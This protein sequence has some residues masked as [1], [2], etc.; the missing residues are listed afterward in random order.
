MAVY[1]Y[2]KLL[3]E[4]EKN[5]KS[6]LSKKNIFQNIFENLNFFKKKKKTK[7]SKSDKTVSAKKTTKNNISQEP[8]QKVFSQEQNMT[9]VKKKSKK[10]L[11]IILIIG[12]LLGIREYNLHYRHKNT[13]QNKV[14]HAQQV[15]VKVK[16]D[17]KKNKKPSNSIVINSTNS[18]V[19]KN[20]SLQKQ[21]LEL[22]ATADK[23][24]SNQANHFTKIEMGKECAK[25]NNTISF[26]IGLNNIFYAGENIFKLKESIPYNNNI[27]VIADKYEYITPQNI[28]LYLK[29]IKGNISYEC[30]VVINTMKNFIIKTGTMSIE[31]TDSQ[32]G[33]KKIVLAGKEAFLNTVLYYTQ[34][35]EAVF[36]TPKGILKIKGQ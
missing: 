4:I 32:S 15:S 35:K 11:Y 28:K 30:P 31:I 17:K 34:D 36:K 6:K 7:P 26:S 12:I 23:N 19:L 33:N 5:K 18:S 24:I 8:A 3:Q 22:N 1:H 27:K 10:W 29:L 9:D 2:Y 20:T 16:T 21:N 13:K 25:I 14:M